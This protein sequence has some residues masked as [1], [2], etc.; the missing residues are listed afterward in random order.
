MDIVSK[1]QYCKHDQKTDQNLENNLMKS[2]NNIKLHPNKQINLQKSRVLKTQSSPMLKLLKILRRT[3]PSSRV[4]LES[5]RT[6]KMR[7][8]VTLTLKMKKSIFK[9]IMSM[10]LKLSMGPRKTIQVQKMMIIKM[11]S[12]K[13]KTDIYKTKTFIRKRK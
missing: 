13:N 9:M 7:M 5:T 3:I 10:P 6:S 2:N 4:A 11:F 8:I 1:K 12:N